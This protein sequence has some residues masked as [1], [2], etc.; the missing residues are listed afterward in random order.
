MATIVIPLRRDP[1]RRKRAIMGRVEHLHRSLA[2]HHH[3]NDTS[4]SN[5][6]AGEF[7]RTAGEDV[8]IFSMKERGKPHLSRY[9]P[10]T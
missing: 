9:Q 6:D 8:A 4:V 3:K 2:K 7:C 10:V 1:D 5:E